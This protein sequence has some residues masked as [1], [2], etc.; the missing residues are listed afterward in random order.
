MG[1]KVEGDYH[2]LEAQMEE[3]EL[4]AKANEGK[5]NRATSEVAR[6]MAELANA[7][8][9][10]AMGDKSRSVLANQVA[11]LQAQL[12]EA[13]SQSGRGLKVQLSKLEM[14]IAELESDAESDARR[15]AEVM[16]QSKKADQR[17]AEIQLS[18]Q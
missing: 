12:E 10:V 14:R 17:V 6:L 8:D 5:A 7:Q 2:D 13:E 18:V 3:L 16:K 11:D 4:E 9:A 15:N 1:R